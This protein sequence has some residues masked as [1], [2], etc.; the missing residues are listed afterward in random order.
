MICRICNKDTGKETFVFREL[1]YGS[2][3]SFVYYLC[4]FCNC[5]QIGTIPSNLK[6]YYPDGYYSFNLEAN[7]SLKYRTKM[8]LY[9]IIS[10]FIGNFFK[11]PSVVK[12]GIQFK[13]RRKKIIDIGCGEG[14]LLKE[15]KEYGFTDLTGVDPFIKEPRLYR[16]LKILK[17]DISEVNERYDIIMSHHSLEHLPDPG[18]FFKIIAQLLN[19]SGRFILRIPIFPNYIWNK[20]QAYWI[21]LDPPRHIYTYSLKGIEM[22]CHR[23]GLE[24]NQVSYDGVPW[25]LAST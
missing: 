25:S 16:H 7:E 20:Y 13:D 22:L 17:K 11:E 14:R 5:L 19:S 24:I 2:N 6:T 1:M 21:Q 9:R 15:M 23:N 8:Y 4:Q 10:F 18:S 3:E 12:F